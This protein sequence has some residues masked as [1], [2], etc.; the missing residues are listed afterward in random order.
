MARD[1]Q[2]GP[3]RLA[4]DGGV[5]EQ[6]E[7]PTDVPYRRRVG[8][9]TFRLVWSLSLFVFWTTACLGTDPDQLTE[10][11]ILVAETDLMAP[12]E[13]EKTVLCDA[14]DIELSPNFYDRAL[15]LPTAS[16]H[17]KVERTPQDDGGTL[18]TY[19]NRVDTPMRVD[20]GKVKYYAFRSVRIRVVGGDRV[21]A[22]LQSAAVGNVR[23]RDDS[24]AESDFVN[25]PRFVL[26]LL[27]G[28]GASALRAT[29][30][31]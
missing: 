17:I 16:V 19:A 8:L 11:E 28:E 25:P 27:P 26:G 15:T 12:F 21:Q 10:E 2:Q 30:A 3:V 18:Y 1:Q 24:V 4:T 23:V 29:P 14:L 6:A 7:R 5:I 22:R 13:S 20:V 31:R 9:T